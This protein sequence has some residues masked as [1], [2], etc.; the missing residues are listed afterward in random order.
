[1]G[2]HNDFGPEGGWLQLYVYG[3][4]TGSS[5]FMPLAFILIFHFKSATEL[6]TSLVL[7]VYSFSFFGVIYKYVRQAFSLQIE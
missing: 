6:R 1:M 2:L 4:P 5:L 3:L 7:L